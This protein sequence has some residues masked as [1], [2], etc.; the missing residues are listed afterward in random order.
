M[1]PEFTSSPR[2]SCWP[3]W[4]LEL[5]CEATAS[6]IEKAARDLIAKIQLGVAGVEQFAT[7]VGFRQRDQYLIREAKALLQ[8]P[9]TRLLGEFWYVDPQTVMQGR[10][11]EKS[12][13]P[14]MWYEALRVKP[15]VA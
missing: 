7:P 4:V 2:Y 6:D 11:K 15:W 5:N 12:W 10:E 8:N 13:T 3:F 9:E 14:S 1:I